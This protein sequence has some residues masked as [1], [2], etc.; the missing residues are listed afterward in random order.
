MTHQML[1]SRPIN[2]ATGLL[3]QPVSLMKP[4]KTKSALAFRPMANMMM[5]N[6]KNMRT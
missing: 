5:Q 6:T 4:V 2:H 1:G 3:S